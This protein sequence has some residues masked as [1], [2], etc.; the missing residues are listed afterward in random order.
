LKYISNKEASERW[1]ISERRIRV[2]CSEGRIDGAVKIGRNWSVPEDAAKPLDARKKEKKKYLGLNYNFSYIDSLKKSIDE[3]RPISKNIVNSLHEKLIVEWTYNSNAIEGNTLTMSETKV[4]LEG[5]TIGGKSMVEHLETINHR[6]AILFIE[7]LVSNKE[8]I[9]EWNFRNIHAL[10]LKEIDNFNAGKYRTENVLISGAKHIP[11]KHFEVG[12]LMQ[13]LVAEFQN[14]WSEYHP[15]VRATLLHGEFVKIHPFVD[16]NGRTAR[17]LLNLELM[18]NGYTPIII[19]N[20][21]RVVYYDALD[22]AHTTMDYGPF[23]KLVSELVVESEKLWLS[24][25]D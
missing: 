7:E 1:Q 9:T 14:Q 25:L 10:I 6:E 16:G 13:K 5:I 22:Y 2:L 21:Q 11:P 15:V 20:E 12:Y 8:N 23:I 3:H 18:K 4:V 24:V 17:L 19:K